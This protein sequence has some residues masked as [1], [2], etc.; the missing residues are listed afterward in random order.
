[1]PDEKNKN[2]LQE[3]TNPRGLP[4]AAV[5]WVLI[6]IVVF[7]LSTVVI[8]L[9]DEERFP[10][11][12]EVATETVEAE[13][14]IQIDV[15]GGTFEYNVVPE[16]SSNVETGTFTEDTTNPV[17]A[18]LFSNVPDVVEV[19]IEPQTITILYD[20]DIESD[21]MLRRAQRPVTNAVLNDS[22]TITSA[23]ASGDA[24]QTLVFTTSDET[25]RYGRYV[26]SLIPQEEEESYNTRE[27]GENGTELAQF[28]FER[29]TALE[30]LTIY[31]DRLIATYRAGAVENQV[32]SR[33]E[34]ALNDYYPRASLQVN[35]WL[36]SLATSSERVL[37]ILPLNTGVPLYLFTLGF[38]VLEFVLYFFY[39]RKGDK[40]IK[41]LV[42]VVGVFF[43]FWS[44]F[45]HEPLWDFVLHGI[46]P[47][48]AQLVHPNATVIEF[49]AQHLELVIVSSL[50]TIPAG[51]L[52]GILVTR[53]DFRE[54]LPLVN[55]LVNSGQTVPTI[56]I[57]A[58]MAPI[59]GFG[60]WPAIIALVAYGLLPVV[61]NTIAGLEAVDDSVID[62]ARGMGMTPMQILLQIELP[63]ASS[64]IMAG[65]RTSMV[66]NV[67]TATLGAFVGSGGLGTPIASGLSMTI[68]AFILLGAIPAALL[69]ILIDYVLGRIEFVMTPR[70]L[71]IER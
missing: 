63:I 53:E 3:N 42:R 7:A 19:L 12:F 41:P 57:V 68:D 6:T 23:A 16:D 27:A 50:I 34:D 46:F 59:I 62:S 51:L 25:W 64:V 22:E 36:F 37:R 66:I 44:I 10:P 43:L 39:Q 17:A 60:F 65:I 24:G 56:A 31:P 47:T 26:A 2:V 8:T 5:V 40:L 33:V 48:S 32:V 1:M 28:L 69:A 71:Q 29:V 58:F 21:L 15:V 38:A 14:T 70:G 35:L 61:R 52:F 30:A 4:V 45:G 54:L 13:N 20:N 18:V 49:A 67:G 11:D 9:H 55:N